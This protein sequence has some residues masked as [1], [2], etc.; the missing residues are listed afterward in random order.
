M[1][2]AGKTQTDRR[3]PRK[4]DQESKS[5]RMQLVLPESL[6]DLVEDWRVKQR[7]APNVSEAIR[8]LVERGTM[9]DTLEALYARLIDERQ[10]LL[11]RLPQGSGSPASQRTL[12]RLQDV[13]AELEKL[14]QGRQKV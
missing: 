12:D 14:R 9:E 7:P 10:E 5:I 3:V 13:E 11:G 1:S 8:Q 6:L 2:A 4:L